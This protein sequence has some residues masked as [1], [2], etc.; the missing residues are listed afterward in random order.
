MIVFKN[1]C[2]KCQHYRFNREKRIDGK[3]VPH[4]Y[5]GLLAWDSEEYYC[6][7]VN[8]EDKRERFALAGIDI[9]KRNFDECPYY[10]EH[11]VNNLVK[12]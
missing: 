11:L 10:M 2:Q 3:I 9:F 6:M 8:L 4:M 1:I 7:D 5:C 12:P